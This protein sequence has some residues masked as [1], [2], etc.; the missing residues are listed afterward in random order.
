MVGSEGI[1]AHVRFSFGY[2]Q[3]NGGI[4]LISAMV[5]AFGFAEVLTAISQ[6]K[7]DLVTH[8]DKS[9]RMLPR[10]V[11]LWRYKF[12]ILRSG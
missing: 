11:D 10:L 12:T 1:H 2:D 9:D 3:L 5:G 8:S 6:R 7:P 4:A